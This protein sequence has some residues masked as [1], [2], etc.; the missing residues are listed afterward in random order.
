MKIMKAAPIFVADSIGKSYGSRAV[1]RS[2]TMWGWPGCVTAMLGRNGSGK[3]TLMRIGAGVLRAD[4]G[5]VMMLGNA[6]L[7]PRLHRLARHG[8]YY[9]ADK[10]GTPIDMTPRRL[11]DIVQTRFKCGSGYDAFDALGVTHLIDTSVVSLSG[12]EQRRVEVA[13]ALARNPVCLIADE[14]FAGISPIDAEQISNAFRM[15]RAA[16]CAIMVSGHEVPSM[17]DLADEV[18]WVTSGTT[19]A[20][21][22]STN[23]QRHHQFCRE[24]LGIKAHSAHA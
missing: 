8:L 5:V 2:A 4:H 21:G 16:G 6:Y 9:L 7:R 3:S 15:L 18:V 1:L 19:H 23:A 10:G 12:G 13:I 22:S 11:M 20:L 17:L 24:Y 14:P